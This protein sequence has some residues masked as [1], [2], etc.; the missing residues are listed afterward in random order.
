MPGATL[1]GVGKS[2][3]AVTLFDGLDLSAGDGE[4]VVLVGPSGCGK[5]TLLRL[6]A[7][8]DRPDSGEIR[9]GE[10][11]VDRLPPGER[12]VAMVFQSYALYP[13]MTVA[14]NIAFPLRMAGR[15]KRELDES[16][17]RT[18]ELL[19]LSELMDRRPAEL[20]G[21]QRQRV[22][23]GRAI[24]RE[25]DVFLFDEPL[26]NLDANLRA[27]MRREFA[28]LHARLRATTIY[29]THDQAE[30][31][32]LADRIVLMRDGRIEQQ[33]TPEDLY[34][35]PATLFA[36]EFFGQPP[37][38]RLPGRIL[39]ADT[40]RTEI[41]IG[42][43]ESIVLGPLTGGGPARDDVVVA[44]RPEA[45]TARPDG[46]TIALAPRAVAFVEWFGGERHAQLGTGDTALVWRTAGDRLIATGE[47]ITLHVAPAKVHLFDDEGRAV[48]HT[49]LP[50]L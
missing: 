44:I 27:Q 45:L 32:A 5:S 18:C 21:G 3:G 28:E 34:C 25:P 40:R 49:A 6:I 1:S 50:N 10:R 14:Q 39:R 9:I 16:V 23:I 4:F 31:M 36:A 7:G 24:V 37:I 42:D 43:G 20:S 47:S 33:G 19:G 48:P 38:N 29:V 17:R 15:P 22:A 12:G 11:Q 2:F 35:R 13:Q 41:A 26:S 8:L 30:A 46:G